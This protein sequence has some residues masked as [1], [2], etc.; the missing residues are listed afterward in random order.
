MKKGRRHRILHHHQ[1]LTDTFQEVV[2][3]DSWQT[4]SL[5]ALL[6]LYQ[7]LYELLVLH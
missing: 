3:G 1:H 7:L 2:L 4:G 5:P 6:Q